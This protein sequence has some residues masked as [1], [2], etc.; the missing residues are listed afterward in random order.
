MPWMFHFAFC[1]YLYLIPARAREDVDV[2]THIESS[3]TFDAFN[4][5]ISMLD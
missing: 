3:S 1:T 4:I 5:S 2:E